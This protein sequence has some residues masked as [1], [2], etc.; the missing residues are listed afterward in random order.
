[1]NTGPTDRVPAHFIC[2]PVSSGKGGTSPTE[3]T[4]EQLNWEATNWSNWSIDQINSGIGTD[5]HGPLKDAAEFPYGCSTA[6]WKHQSKTG[7]SR[8]RRSLMGT[9]KAEICRSIEGNS[10][11]QA[12]RLEINHEW[13]NPFE[14]R[15]IKQSSWQYSEVS[16][17]KMC[18]ITK[19]EKK[20][21]LKIWMV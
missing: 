14:K 17:V 11:K 2:T 10:I 13:Y 12:K 18:K 16:T 6:G 4:P 7:W 20:H 1:M 8:S 15:A 5:F 21:Q 3:A 19:T 9:G